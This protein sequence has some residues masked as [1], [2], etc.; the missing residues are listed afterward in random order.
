MKTKKTKNLNNEKHYIGVLLENM[1]SKIDVLVDGHKFLV[2]GQKVLENRMDSLEGKM[3][4]GFMQVNFRLDNIE[5]DIADIR[6]H[7]VY[8][9]EFDDLTARVKYL[10]T[11]LGIEG[12]K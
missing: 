9:D 5:R 12:G 3:D 1:D 11:K 4:K 6:K 2:E 7:F 8:R 10:E